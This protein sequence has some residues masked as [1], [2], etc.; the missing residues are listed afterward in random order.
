[1]DLAVA[2]WLVSAEA[3][4]WLAAA[5]QEV[6]PSS[7]A[8][9][10]RMRRDLAAPRAAA[11]LEQA[12]LRQRGQAKLGRRDLFLTSA[13]LEQASRPAVTRWR[14]ERL[15]AAGARRV[16]DLGCGLGLDTVALVDAGLAVVAVEQDP[17]TAVLAQANLVHVGWSGQ[18][19]VIDAAE[20]IGQIPATDAVFADPARR[21][22]RGRSSDPA[23]LSPPWQVLRP[24]LH[25]GRLACIKLGPGVPHAMVP[26]ETETIWVSDHHDLVEASLWGGLG[27]R[28][29]ALLLP[30]GQ[31]LDAGPDCEV[32]EL[33][34]YLYE[35]DPAV[36]R[37]GAVGSLARQLGAGRVASRIAYLTSH[38][39]AETDLATRFEILERL[40]WRESQLRS[41]VRKHQIGSLEIKK[42][43]IETD[44]A[45]LRR[46]LRPNGPRQATWVITP[47]P[48]AAAVLVVRR[49]DLGSERPA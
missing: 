40:P 6:D 26:D 35:P 8:A 42:R 10:T 24:L 48:G 47:T 7:L 27:V 13:G 21:T 45:A 15:A 14:A 9:A 46:R 29:S 36:I 22:G 18:V 2:R 20:V 33:G 32:H 12:A 17:V 44:P 4:P 28:R 39:P 11:V 31:Q 16:W 49:T 1:M 41:W 43:G 37:A 25:H 23:D 5:E 38:Y 19:R 30:G 3:Q 34:R